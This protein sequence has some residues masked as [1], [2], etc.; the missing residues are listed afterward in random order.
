VRYSGRL[1]L[2]LDTT[3]IL[4]A[5]GIEVEGVEGVL[6]A[7]QRLRRHRRV[8]VYYSCYSIL[9]AL[10]KLAKL[11]YDLE[12]VRRGLS[13]IEE[14][15]G[16]V[17]PTLE[18][19]L[20]ALELRRRGFPDIIDLLLYATALTNGILFLTR[21]RRLYSFLSEEGEETGAILLEEDF[22]RGYA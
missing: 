20:K 10:W 16:E 7:L 19:Y 5:L 3:Y 18:G 9:E 14:D 6:E 11:S 13:L 22:L 12:V 1:R 17:H 8:E 15:F 4:P 21:D 2:L